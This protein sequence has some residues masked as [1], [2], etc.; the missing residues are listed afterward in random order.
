[1]SV[2]FS[3][4]G[5]I[6]AAGA[7]DNTVQMW[8]ANSGA[9]LRTLEGHQGAVTG[10]AFTPD[11]SRIATTGEDGALRLW[12]TK[13]GRPFGDPQML[14]SGLLADLAMTTT[15]RHVITA[16]SD[17]SVAITLADATPAGL[18]EMLASNM[19]MAHWREWVSSSIEYVEACPGL[20]QSRDADG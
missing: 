13:T 6:I 2:A 9:H 1:M 12:E 18:C 4:R 14:D 3:P 11:G 20:P 10:V 15:S 19:S 5:D 7:R 8:D 16:G 17:R